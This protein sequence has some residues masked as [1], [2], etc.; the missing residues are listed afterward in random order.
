METIRV[1]TGSQKSLAPIPACSGSERTMQATVHHLKVTIVGT[2][3]EVWR[4]V[5]VPSDITLARL[6]PVLQAAFG[7]WDC[8]PHEFHVAGARYGVPR[9][10]GGGSSCQ[11]EALARLGALVPEGALFL[12]AYEVGDYRFHRVVVERVEHVNSGPWHGSCAGNLKFNRRPTCRPP[13][14]K[15]VTGRRSLVEAEAPGPL[16]LREN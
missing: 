6:H 5:I 15:K 2:E 16:A 4:R 3:P 8:H 11:D 1:R 10:A 7:F 9:S 13:R 14:T 12:Y